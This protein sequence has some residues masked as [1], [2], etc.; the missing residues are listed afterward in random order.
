MVYSYIRNHRLLRSIHDM[1]CETRAFT[2]IQLKL[3]TY[4]KTVLSNDAHMRRR[5]P[6]R[7][8]F[9]A[10]LWHILRRPGAR[11]VNRKPASFKNDRIVGIQKSF[12]LFRWSDRLFKNGKKRRGFKLSFCAIPV[13]ETSHST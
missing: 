4:F 8:N 9:M 1:L 3:P 2:P 10:S 13:G 11:A 7:Q 5:W 6:P 12:Y